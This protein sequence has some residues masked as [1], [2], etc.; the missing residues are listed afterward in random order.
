MHF[1]RE[2]TEMRPRCEA[3]IE[4]SR[5]NGLPFWLAAG[6]MCLGRTIIGE[7]QFAGDEAAMTSGLAILKESVE[8]LAA[9]G[10]DLNYSFSFVLLAE[11]YLMM[12]R[13]E[14][15][16]RELDQGRASSKRTIASWKRKFTGSG[17][18]RCCSAGQRHGSRAQF[19][20]CDRNS[21]APTERP[22]GV[23]RL[24]PASR[25]CWRAP[26]AARRLAQHLPGV[27][28]IHGRILDGRSSRSESDARAVTGERSSD[29]IIRPIL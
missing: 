4:L 21:G 13:P 28:A 10:A 23:A 12:K 18:K 17:A 25:G 15:S 2:Y 8:S 22:R 20:A 11:V 7:G 1:R 3:L 26:A 9:G 27:M 5:E 6:K 29:Q 24:R 14:D 19:S 16:L